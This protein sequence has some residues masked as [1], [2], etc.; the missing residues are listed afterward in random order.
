MQILGEAGRLAAMND[1]EAL[2]AQVLSNVS[3]VSGRPF[4]RRPDT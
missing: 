4:R 2:A 1:L 3:R